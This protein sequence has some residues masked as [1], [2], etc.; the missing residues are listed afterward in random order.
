MI[1]RA[2]AICT[3][4]NAA[5]ASGPRVGVNPRKIAAAAPRNAALERTATEQLSHLRAP[6]SI[7][8]DWRQIIAYR[9]L[10]AVELSRLARVAKAGDLSR[11]FALSA[12]KKSLHGR[13]SALA[14]RDG[15]KACARIG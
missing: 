15:F 9:R 4:L 6:A 13:L 5:L 12:S 1:A 10:L 3:K 2:E 11:I 8:A 7:A 14:T